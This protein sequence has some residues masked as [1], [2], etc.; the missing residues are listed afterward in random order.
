[1]TNT[2]KYFLGGNYR[3]EKKLEQ[4]VMEGLQQLQ[5]LNDVQKREAMLLACEIGFI[6]AASGLT[7][8]QAR[9]H[10]GEIL[11]KAKI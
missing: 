8:N 5:K 3:M 6:A 4:V 10:I 2:L 1:M 7:L 11:D 9:D